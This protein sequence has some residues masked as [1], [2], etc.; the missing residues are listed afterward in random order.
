MKLND[1]IGIGE[2]IKEYDECSNEYDKKALDTLIKS[3]EAW[4]KLIMEITK[5]EDTQNGGIK[6]VLSDIKHTIKKLLM[7][8]EK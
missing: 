6:L 5:F 8:V 3:A 1:A 7:E 2:E 4:P